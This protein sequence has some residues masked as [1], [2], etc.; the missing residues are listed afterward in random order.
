[1]EKAR[2]T[3]PLDLGECDPAWRGIVLRICVNPAWAV[4]WQHR[5]APTE[6]AHALDAGDPVRIVEADRAL[7]PLMAEIWGE[8]EADVTEFYFE[9]GYRI[10]CWSVVGSLKLVVIHLEQQG[11]GRLRKRQMG[12]LRREIELWRYLN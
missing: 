3:K 4:L 12:I 5:A 2:I 10:W 7:I 8:P 9:A 6:W 11:K 1:M